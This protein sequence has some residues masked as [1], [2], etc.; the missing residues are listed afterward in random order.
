MKY[1]IQM[2]YLLLEHEGILLLKKILEKKLLSKYFRLAIL[3]KIYIIYN[4]IIKR[5][6]MIK[7]I[8]WE[9]IDLFW[10]QYADVLLYI[11]A[12]DENPVIENEDWPSIEWSESRLTEVIVPYIE[13]KTG[14]GKDDILNN[15]KYKLIDI[16]Y[17][18]TL[19]KEKTYLYAT[20]T[21]IWKSVLN[22]KLAKYFESKDK[23]SK[24]DNMHYFRVFDIVEFSY[25]LET[26]LNIDLNNILHFINSHQ[27]CWEW[28]HEEE[29]QSELYFILQEINIKE[30]LIENIN[31]WK[32]ILWLFNAKIKNEVNDKWNTY[33][34]KI[35]KSSKYKELDSYHNE[36]IEW[37]YLKYFKDEGRLV[38]I[39]WTLDNDIYV[40]DSI[41]SI[42]VNY[43]KEDL[44]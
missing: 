6:F 4:I 26:W 3:Y 31:E 1:E 25:S 42:L 13:K 16:W 11:I 34:S 28:Y 2:K 37:D 20:L 39:L 24:E 23:S 5:Q 43:L 35:S 33:I 30:W 14:I 18:T 12:V 19:E 40:Y 15:I 32:K 41:Y 7:Q 22:R 44:V 8:E 29:F 36:T 17:I 10:N 21:N 38:F 27:C 9:L